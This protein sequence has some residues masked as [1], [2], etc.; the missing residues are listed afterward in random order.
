MA[1]SQIST[2]MP[3]GVWPVSF[4]PCL[5]QDGL[6]LAIELV[7]MAM[8]FA[9]LVGAVGCARKAA[10]RQLAGIR[11]QAHRA[12]QFV[13]AFQFA[14]LVDDA[15][16]RRGIELGRIRRFSSPQTLRAYSITIVCMPR[17]MPK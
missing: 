4:R 10:F 16:R 12:A 9:D 6:E 17:Q 15:V 2:Y 7:A 13:D 14:K 5:G 8:A 1:I 3:S 11:A